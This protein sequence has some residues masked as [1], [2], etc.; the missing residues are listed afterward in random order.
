MVDTQAG[1]LRAHNVTVRFQG[2][3]AINEVSLS[4][5]PGD[6]R[7]LIGPNGAGKTT[8]VNV[9]S[10]LEA[11]SCGHVTLDGRS[12]QGKPPHQFRR[13]GIA[14]TF[15]SG[16]LFGEL[17]VAENVIVPAVNLGFTPRQATAHARE[18][19][20]WVNLADKTELTAGILAGTDNRR[21][22]IARALA[23][24]PRFILLDEPAAGMSEI[25]CEEIT[26]LITAIPQTFGAGVL[27]ID[28]N[29]GVVMRAC[30]RI[31]VLDSGR[32]IA[33]GAPA[34][35]RSSQA[36]ISAYLGTVVTGQRRRVNV[37]AA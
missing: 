7:G 23:A 29:M 11:P 33:E 2:I 6:I 15:Q 30:E 5:E 17:T 1:A 27:L 28:H 31:H 10:G 25:E 9:L 12:L 36:V 24:N 13:K 4:L 22:G 14:R 18:L 26:R 32:M 20:A 3:T 35:V 19:L 21:L 34:E 37:D 16:R 8:L